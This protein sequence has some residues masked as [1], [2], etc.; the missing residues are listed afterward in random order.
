[1]GRD[2]PA[3]G[4]R[5]R[6]ATMG[7]DP[8]VRSRPWVATKDRDQG[9]RPGAWGPI[10]E[11]PTHATHAGG[12]GGVE[13]ILLHPGQGTLTGREGDQGTTPKAELRCCASLPPIIAVL[14]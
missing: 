6:I 10:L 3:T 4:L 11:E 9:P 14:V 7:L 5:S 12:P 13:A 8:V 2:Q 1:M